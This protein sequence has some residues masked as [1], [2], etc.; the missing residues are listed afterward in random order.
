TVLRDVSLLVRRG[1]R[2]AIIG[3]NGLGKSTLLKIATANVNSD[4]GKVSWGHEAH[5]GYF[6]QDHREILLDPAAT[7]LGIISDA[8]PLD[9]PSVIRG[10]LGR[11]LFSGDDVHKKV[12]ALSGGEAARVVFCRVMVQNPNVL[13][14]DEPTNHLDLE[15]IQALVEALLEFEGTLLFVSH[16]RAFVSALATRILEVTPQGFRDFPGTY[17]EYLA[18]SGDDHLDAEAVV[19]RAK[20]DRADAAQPAA[21]TL[22]WEAQKRRANRKKQLPVQR[23]RVLA[24][25]EVAEIRSKQLKE[26]WGDPEFYSRTAPDQIAKLEL[27]ERELAQRIERLT[28]EWEALETEIESL[29]DA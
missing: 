14:L 28:S 10:Q 19:L 24:D 1:E 23:D 25:I 6:P 21:A 2:V 26:Q 3:P 9:G 20:R 22:S 12:A 4:A 11:V 16:D 13:V 18:R 7:P 27:E 29:A 17:D 5:V 15:S 8:L